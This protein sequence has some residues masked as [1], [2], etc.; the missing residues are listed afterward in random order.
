[1]SGLFNSLPVTSARTRVVRGESTD[2]DLTDFLLPQTIVRRPISSLLALRHGELP[3]T[4]NDRIPDPRC[5]LNVAPEPLA[6]RNLTAMSV[7]RTAIGQSVA[8]IVRA[9]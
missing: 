9:L 5:R 3:G 2:S 8:A 6:L 1:V 7:N 4:L